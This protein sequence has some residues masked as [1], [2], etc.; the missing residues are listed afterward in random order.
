[1]LAKRYNCLEVFSL[2]QV[3]AIHFAMF[4]WLALLLP[5]N[6]HFDVLRFLAPSVWS[7]KPQTMKGIANTFSAKKE[8][9]RIENKTKQKGLQNVLHTAK[10]QLKGSSN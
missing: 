10:S 4:Q 3:G 9:E 1:M 6:F 8:K 5:N 2:N 7:P